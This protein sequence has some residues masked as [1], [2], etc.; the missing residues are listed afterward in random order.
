MI[1]FSQYLLAVLGI[2]STFYFLLKGL[3]E[4]DMRK[5]KIAVVIFLATAGT[6]LLL[7]GI[8]WMFTQQI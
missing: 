4:N 3:M 5:Y 8:E 1:A 7:A 6:I 2:T